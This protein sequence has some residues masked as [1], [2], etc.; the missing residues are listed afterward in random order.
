MISSRRVAPGHSP[1]FF[2]QNN[3]HSLFPDFQPV[4]KKY[5]FQKWPMPFLAC[6]L[7]MLHYTFISR[8]KTAF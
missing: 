1:A 7:K 4:S 5:L 3:F 8:Q 2:V 6:F